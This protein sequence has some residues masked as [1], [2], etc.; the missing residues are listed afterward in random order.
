MRSAILRSELFFTPS[1]FWSSPIPTA[2]TATSADIARFIASSL[3]SR[4]VVSTPSEMSMMARR[5]SL[6]ISENSSSLTA[7]MASQIAVVPSRGSSLPDEGGSWA[8]NY[9]APSYVSGR[10]NNFDSLQSLLYARDPVR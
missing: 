3:L 4:L 2:Y 1:K 9:H 10:Q 6:P 5:F 8:L 7:H